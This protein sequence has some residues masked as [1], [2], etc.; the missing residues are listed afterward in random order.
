MDGV[1]SDEKK[2]AV[3]T[4]RIIRASRKGR[5]WTQVETSQKIGISQSAL[6]KMEAGQLIPSVHQW[7]EFCNQ[8]NIPAD[9]HIMG[10]LDRMEPVTLHD[11]IPDHGFKVKKPYADYAGSTARSLFPLLRWTEQKLGLEKTEDLWKELGV[12]SDYFVDFSNPI[13]FRF[14]ADLTS[15]LK[16]KGF[17]K[18]S[19]FAKL[20]QPVSD[21][22]N[23]GFL[24]KGYFQASDAETLFKTV[25]SRSNY[26]EVN[27]E[28]KVEEIN[29]KH[30]VFSARPQEHLTAH[31]H[32]HLGECQDFLCDYRG[33][34]FK[35]LSNTLHTKTPLQTKELSCYFKG[36]DRC[37]HEVSYL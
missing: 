13:N 23:H 24:G 35:S 17:F 8:A 4:G 16:N 15:L 14:Y 37:V 5:G 25:F 3:K 36:A 19:D 33:N 26:Y 31:E 11:R 10:Y 20:T 9:S 29:R 12:D 18:K 22:K 21:P 28:Y 30:T 6:S 34:Y 1:T 2:A 7:F 32:L 27:F